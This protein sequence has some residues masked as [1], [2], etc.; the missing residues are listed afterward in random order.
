MSDSQTKAAA[1]DSETLPALLKS[2]DDPR[3]KELAGPKEIRW[4]G[5]LLADLSGRSEHGNRLL[6]AHHVLAIHLVGFFNPMIRSLRTFDLASQSQ[7]VRELV[8]MPRVCRSTHSDFLAVADPELLTPLIEALRA[9]VPDLRRRDG[10]LHELLERTVLF[11]GTY[12]EVPVTVAWALQDTLRAHPS[13]KEKESGV[14][15]PR[16][17]FA[18]IRLNL[19]YCSQSGVAEGV[20]VDGG[21]GGEAQA[22]M[23]HLEKDSIY[24]ADRGLFSFDLVDAIVQKGGHY[25]LRLKKNIPF[26]PIEERPLIAEDM[27][28]GVI[29]DRIGHFKGSNKHP[30]PKHLSREVLM[31]DPQRPDHPLRLVTDMR[32]VPAENLGQLY[33]ERWGVELFFRW[34]KTFNN[35]K[36]LVTHS[37]EGMTFVFYI[38][39]IALLLHAILRGRPASKY[40]I[41]VYQL[42]LSQGHSDPGLLAGLKRLERERELARERYARKKAMKKM[43]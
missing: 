17:R 35:F 14:R 4:L 24:V 43:A 38:M 5:D 29:A 28:R 6:K 30:P 39:V 33:Q 25:V 7:T 36:H 9:K 21:E 32:E 41:L 1:W 19:H 37:R 42:S 13:A 12:F 23:R 2:S 15:H 26:I 3:L 27:A 10:E 11:D 22:M 16:R 8:D 34:L 20:S 40:D 31:A 18:H